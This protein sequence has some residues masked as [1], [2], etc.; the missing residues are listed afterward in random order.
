MGY[1]DPDLDP[2]HGSGE[3][4][5]S[6]DCYSLG[7]LVLV[8]LTGLKAFDRAQPPRHRRL[9]ARLHAAGAAPPTAD[10]V[11]AATAGAEA[12][13]A[14]MGKVGLGLTVIGETETRLTAAEAV[15]ELM[16]SEDGAAA[17]VTAPPAPPQQPKM[18]AVCLE[19][20]RA[21]RF[22]PCGHSVAC[23]ACAQRLMEFA[24]GGGGGGRSACPLCRRGIERSVALSADDEGATFVST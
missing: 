22:A 2:E 1:D 15:V 21:T 10:P 4:R 13:L 12:Q 6:C 9:A 3:A 19:S 8:L 16:A 18:C 7:V 24:R 20:A 17:P 5:A 23:A 11:L 14:A